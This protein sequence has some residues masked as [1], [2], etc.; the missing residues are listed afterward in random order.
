MERFLAGGKDA[1]KGSNAPAGV[2]PAML[3]TLKGH[4]I[5]VQHEK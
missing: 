1:I 5:N 4:S 3:Q 2:W